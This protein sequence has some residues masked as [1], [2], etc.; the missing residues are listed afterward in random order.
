MA[1]GAFGSLL[2]LCGE[3]ETLVEFQPSKLDEIAAP[4]RPVVVFEL[5]IRE[6]LEAFREVTPALGPQSPRHVTHVRLFGFRPRDAP[7]E[8]DHTRSRFPCFIVEFT[9]RFRV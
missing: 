7:F 5:V 4:A 6:R 9:M 1:H 3:G 8:S 2:H